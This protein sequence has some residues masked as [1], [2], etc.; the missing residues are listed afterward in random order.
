MPTIKKPVARK[1]EGRKVNYGPNSRS[2]LIRFFSKKARFGAPYQSVL[3]KK[4][5]ATHF[6]GIFA[7]APSKYNLKGLD[8]LKEVL[9]V[10]ETDKVEVCSPIYNI[11]KNPAYLESEKALEIFRENKEEITL[12]VKVPGNDFFGTLFFRLDGAKHPEI[13][14][15]VLETLAQRDMKKT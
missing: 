13:V 6:S 10:R 9:N 4:S 15:K 1:R 5:S 3:T 8:E 7:R 2:K 14:G 12:L 11:G